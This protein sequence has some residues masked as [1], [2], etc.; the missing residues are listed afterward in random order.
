MAIKKDK[1]QSEIEDAI[2]ILG[3]KNRTLEGNSL[4][5]IQKIGNQI[6]KD[7]LKKIK[8]AIDNETY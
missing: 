8:K 3:D 5:D 1:N 6:P 2:L 7:N 4:E